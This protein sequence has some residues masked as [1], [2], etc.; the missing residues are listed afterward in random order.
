MRMERSSIFFLALLLSACGT[1]IT[2]RA[3]TGGLTGAAIGGIV[4]GPVGMAVG[5][6][7]GAGGGALMP[8]SADQMA[9]DIFHG[10]GV[11]A[12]SEQP[13]ESAGSGMTSHPSAGTSQPP[14][15]RRRDRRDQPGREWHRRPCKSRPIWSGRCRP[16]S[17]IRGFMTVRWTGS[18]ARAPAADWP[19]LRRVTG[20]RASIWK[21]CRCSSVRGRA[22]R[23]ARP[24]C[25]RLRP[26]AE[27]AVGLRAVQPDTTL[28][29]QLVHYAKASKSELQFSQESV[30]D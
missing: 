18:S 5:G 24:T 9:M 20:S 26:A 27:A 23:T 2:Q 7:V 1:N 6:A 15:R 25:P 10:K 17:R 8:E 28:R 4:G 29:H 13:A 3:A 12:S 16:T 21:R 22:T 14:R 19:T 30:D 11:T